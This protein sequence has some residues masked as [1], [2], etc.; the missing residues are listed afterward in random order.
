M[1][2]PITDR[3]FLKVIHK[4]YHPVFLKSESRGFEQHNSYIAIS[5]IKIAEKLGVDEAEVLGRMYYHL[6][7]KHS[8]VRNDNNQYVHLFKVDKVETHWVHIHLLTG[9]LAK[10]EEEH[11]RFTLPLVASVAALLLSIYGV[12]V[13][14][15]TTNASTT[16]PICTQSDSCS[17]TKK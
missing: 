10:S 3:K 15:P 8:Y 1:I 9:V 6:D 2:G 14:S 5:T 13:N 4:L 16:V 17:A 11:W 7:T 12:L